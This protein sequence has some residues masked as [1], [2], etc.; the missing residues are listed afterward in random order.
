MRVELVTNKNASRA[1]HVAVMDFEVYLAPGER[2]TPALNAS[3]AALVHSAAGAWNIVH[4]LD[5]KGR[6]H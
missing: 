2:L 4:D 1:L 6:S 3:V 5:W